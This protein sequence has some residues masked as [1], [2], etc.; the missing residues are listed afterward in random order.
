MLTSFHS[1]EQVQSVDP[2]D[3]S[4]QVV[5]DY[6]Q[7]DHW[8]L[9][10]MTSA[11]YVPP[12]LYRIVSP[13]SIENVD[14]DDVTGTD[15]YDAY[16]TSVPL[17]HPLKLVKQ[18]GK[19]GIMN[20]GDTIVIPIEYDSLI[21]LTD[22]GPQKFI[23]KKG[24]QFG[25]IDVNNNAVIP[26]EY[27]RIHLLSNGH[28]LGPTWSSLYVEKNGKV[29]LMKTDGS[30]EL[31]CSYDYIDVACKQA[32]CPKSGVQ[33]YVQK[34]GK[35]GYINQD[36]TVA[37]EFKYEELD[38]TGFSGLIKARNDGLVGLMD[39]SGNFVLPQKYDQLYAEYAGRFKNL[40]AFKEKGKWGLMYG[41]YDAMKTIV[42]AAYDSIFSD[43]VF[44][45]HFILIEAGKWGLVDTNGRLVVEPKYQEIQALEDGTF[46]Y[47][48]SGRWG[49]MNDQGLVHCSPRYDSIY[50][51]N[52]HWCLVRRGENY[53]FCKTSGEQVIEPSYSPPYYDDYMSWNE[54]LYDGRIALMKHDDQYNCVMGVID[55]NGRVLVP[56]EYECNDDL[57]YRFGDGCIVVSKKGKQVLLNE[58]G[59]EV[60]LGDYDRIEVRDE[61][62][63]FFVPRKGEKMGLVSP[64]GER[65]A[66]PRYDD[67]SFYW[68]GE[69]YADEMELFIFVEENGKT[70]LLDSDGKT[71][72]E[73][74]YDEV[75]FGWMDFSS[76]GQGKRTN[77][78]EYI[79][80]VAEGDSTEKEEAPRKELFFFVKKD[81]KTGVMTGNKR[82]LID[83]LYDDIGFLSKESLVLL[84]GDQLT[85]LNLNT[86][87]K[88]K[89]K[90]R[91]LPLFNGY[92]GVLT[93]A[94][95]KELF[96]DA[97]GE[98][99]D[100]KMYDRISKCS[101]DT[102]Y[103]EVQFSGQK[104]I[105]DRSGKELFSPKFQK[106]K[107]WDGSFGAGK[108]GNYYC[109]FNAKGDTIVGYHY[110]KV[111]G[112]YENF[113]S[114][115]MND[116][117]GVVTKEGKV[118]LEPSLNRK[119][120]FSE[121]EKLGMTVVLGPHYG[122]VDRNMQVI[123]PTEYSSI[124]I[125]QVHDKTYFM[126]RKDLLWALYT[127][128]GNPMSFHQFTHWEQTPIGELF[129][130]NDNKLY[131]L[132]D[133]DEI[134]AVER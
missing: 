24:G 3:T 95:G 118:V 21:R 100:R 105:C 26:L 110:E 83:A 115:R 90:P 39:T 96:V 82:A 72:L 122:V 28:Y 20:P 16:Y 108:K 119:V 9:Y 77:H 33:Y 131:H 35:Y 65:I 23:V 88:T 64:K 45:N 60:D 86:N 71:L 7:Y 47:K 5:R 17:E 6:F 56:F 128:E 111:K 98:W 116:H 44:P 80:V 121:L 2:S 8:R 62:W 101:S 132:T 113:V 99:L 93:L 31:S 18:R 59:K 67:I 114:V 70:G 29:G 66:V 133:T 11:L 32:D 85:V 79:R 130:Y 124:R 58:N 25:L 30:T 12:C 68:T 75:T 42:P 63:S 127:A 81:G 38:A 74:I 92:V 89:V 117:F 69:R 34:N 73:P 41:D 49:F 78:P 37:I 61:Q 43:P 76:K 107:Y 97:D 104:G 46:G 13:D 91:Q 109:F 106:I 103:F 129:L 10:P 94:S 40:T 87:E 1:Y 15:Y 27:D 54:L 19:Y 112:V 126:I 14:Y 4:I 120:N 22:F 53:G 51:N 134:E 52:G 102:A 84:S 48:L 50:E 36:E 55:S 57:A 123:I 125:I